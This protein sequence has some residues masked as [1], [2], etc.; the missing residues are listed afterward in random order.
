MDSRGRFYRNSNEDPLHVDLV[1]SHYASRSATSASATTV[2]GL[3]EELTPNTEVWPAHATPAVNRGYQPR[4]LRADSSL[5]RY[6]S[7]SSPTAYVG[8]RLPAE[9]RD[10]VFVTEPAGNLVARRLAPVNR[11][12]VA[13]PAYFRRHGVPR[14]PMEPNITGSAP[15]RW[16]T[17]RASASIPVRIWGLMAKAALWSRRIRSMPRPSGC[18][19]TGVNRAAIIM[20]CAGSIT[21][22]RAFR[23]PF[24]G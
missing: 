16:R 1:S 12:I 5:Q 11:K 19:E 4:V 17:L 3:Y 21:A 2:R 22:W 15:G 20:T 6:T 18:C 10:N 9:L 7:A 23:E 8:D 14:K 13:T 24:C